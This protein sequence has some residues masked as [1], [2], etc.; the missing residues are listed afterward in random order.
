MTEAYNEAYIVA[1]AVGSFTPLLKRIPCIY[2]PLR[3]KKNQAEIQSLIDSNNKVN[4][5]ILAYIKRLGF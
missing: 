4:T 3:F 2:Y 1:P 5:M